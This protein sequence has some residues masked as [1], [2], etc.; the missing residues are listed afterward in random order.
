MQRGQLFRTPQAQ[1]ARLRHTRDFLDLIYASGRSAVWLQ[2]AFWDWLLKVIPQ[3]QIEFLRK[4]RSQNVQL[5]PDWDWSDIQ[6]RLKGGFE[7]ELSTVD[8]MYTKAPERPGQRLNT[9]TGPDAK[10]YLHYGPAEWD[11]LDEGGVV[12]LALGQ[13]FTD[14][15]G[16]AVEVLGRCE[17]CRRYFI[18]LRGTRKK[19]CSSRCTWRAFTKAKKVQQRRAKSKRARVAVS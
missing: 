3:S 6:N 10:R 2:G 16:L 8:Q 7:D 18:R 4:A 1:Q 11:S 12:G 15:H 9:W 17:V 19:Y 13:V 14:L 5:F